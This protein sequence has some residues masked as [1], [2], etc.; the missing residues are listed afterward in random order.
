MSLSEQIIL[1]KNDLGEVEEHLNKLQSGRKASSS[2]ARAG[3]MK[4]KKG[5]H[6]FDIT[7]FQKELPVKSRSKKEVVVQSPEDFKVVE[8]PVEPVAV[9]EE[10]LIIADAAPTLCSAELGVCAKTRSVCRT[11]S[12]SPKDEVKQSSK[13]KKIRK[14]KK[15]NLPKE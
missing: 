1:M 8:E 13:P 15:V 3:L 7:K 4:L 9:V 11:G 5:S 2:K 6:Q 10:P 14:S 12:E